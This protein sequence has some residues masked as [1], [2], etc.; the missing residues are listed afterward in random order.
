MMSIM[1]FWNVKSWCFTTTQIPEGLF[2]CMVDCIILLHILQ[3]ICCDTF[4]LCCID[5]IQLSSYCL[6]NWRRHSTQTG[7]KEYT[8]QILM[9]FEIPLEKCRNPGNFGNF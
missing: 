6:G 7:T 4:P 9:F 8:L 2:V 1:S 3:V 5:E